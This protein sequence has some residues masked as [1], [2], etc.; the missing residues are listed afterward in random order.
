MKLDLAGFGLA[1]FIII[2]T[3]SYGCSTDE[4]SEA[5]PLLYCCETAVF[6]YESLN[7]EDDNILTD[8]NKLFKRQTCFTYEEWKH[9]EKE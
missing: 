8:D 1:I 4:R 6:E 3:I 2:F 5:E 7:D 9:G